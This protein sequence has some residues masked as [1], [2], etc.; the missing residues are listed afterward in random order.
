MAR[1]NTFL[2]VLFLL[3]FVVVAENSSGYDQEEAINPYLRYMNA[4]LITIYIRK[5]FLVE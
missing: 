1:N 2:I 4:S 5:K 3:F